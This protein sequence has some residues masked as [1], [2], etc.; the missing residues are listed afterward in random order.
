MGTGIRYRGLIGR[1]NKRYIC[2]NPRMAVLWRC[3]KQGRDFLAVQ[4]LRHCTYPLRGA[5]SILGQLAKISHVSE[6]A[7]FF[8][9]KERRGSS[10]RWGSGRESKKTRNDAREIVKQVSARWNL[11]R[12]G[13]METPLQ[14]R[15]WLGGSVAISSKNRRE[16][17]VNVGKGEF[18][19]EN[20][21]KQILI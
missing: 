13:E 2:P 6:H 20:L 11:P 7:K 14:R 5:G 16:R 10:W 12:V 4:W 3:L 1:V 19:A 8:F 15:D 17:Q 18:Q 21:K 9:L